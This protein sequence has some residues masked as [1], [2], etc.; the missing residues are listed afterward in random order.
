MMGHENQ[1][2]EDAQIYA[3]REEMESLVL[4]DENNNNSG[5][6]NNPPSRSNN[7]ENG[8]CIQHQHPLSSTLPFAEIPTTDDDDPLLSSSSPQKSPNSFNSSM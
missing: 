4:D 7:G 8:G 1:G 5:N 6:E 3:S 2:F